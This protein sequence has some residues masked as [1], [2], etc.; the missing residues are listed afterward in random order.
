VLFIA[1]DDLS[2]M[3]VA[4]VIYLLTVIKVRSSF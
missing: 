3:L 1:V 4:A 2:A